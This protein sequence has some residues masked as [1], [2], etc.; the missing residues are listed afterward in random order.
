MLLAQA[1]IQGGQ[2]ADNL[3]LVAVRWEEGYSRR[4]SDFDPDDVA[5]HDS[6]PRSTTVGAATRRHKT[7]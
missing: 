6:P 7:D 3:S 2:H 4:S 5:R 1:D